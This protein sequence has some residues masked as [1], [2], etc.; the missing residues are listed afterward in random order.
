MKIN[1]LLPLI[2]FISGPPA[3]RNPNDNFDSSLGNI[4]TWLILKIL[5]YSLILV[6][7]L[8]PNKLINFNQRDIKISDTKSNILFFLIFISLL[9]SAV[10]GENTTYS[11][12]YT[13][14]YSSSFILFY[15]FSN[16]FVNDKNFLI[17]TIIIIRNI[18]ILIIILTLIFYLLKPEFVGVTEI[19]NSIR[20]TGG[21]FS[22][23]KFIPL[24]TYIISVIL[25]LDDTDKNLNKFNFICILISLSAL[26]FS[27]TRSIIFL[28]IVITFV[29]TSYILIS[30]TKDLFNLKKKIII[31]YSIFFLFIFLPKNF[32]LDILSRSNTVGIFDLSGRNFIWSFSFNYMK[33]TFFGYGIGSGFKDIFKNLPDVVYYDLDKILLTKNI[34]NTHNFYIEM[35]FAG[36]WV[37]FLS[38][39]FLH[40]IFILRSLML[41]KKKPTRENF[42]LFFIFIS[43]SFVGFFDSFFIVPASNSYAIYWIVCAMIFANIKKY[44]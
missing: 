38:I 33:E 17:N 24:V 35:L 11:I 34:G 14:L 36:G 22:D 32:F 26:F 40:I 9:I 20:I 27:L 41:L 23:F 29:Y 18:L 19:E 13:F 8:Y 28:S 6:F 31:F 25:F 5:A 16:V 42:I 7:F 3:L 1:L 2:L 30:K 21:K 37:S 43:I 39:I 15:F 44:E 12:F 10:K 4:D